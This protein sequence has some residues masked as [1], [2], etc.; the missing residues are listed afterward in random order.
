MAPEAPQN[1]AEQDYADL[2]NWAE[3]LGLED[4]QKEKF[5]NSSMKRLGYKPRT[6]WEPP[7]PE[8]DEGKGKGDDD[9]FGGSGGKPAG[10]QQ[11]E[12]RGGGSNWQYE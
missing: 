10:R 4:E 6:Q 8:G 1:P 12:V 7:E 2:S 9:F 3:R 11:R 5:I